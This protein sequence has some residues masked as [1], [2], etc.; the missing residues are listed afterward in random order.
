VDAREAE[1]A[2]LQAQQRRDAHLPP[3]VHRRVD[4]PAVAPVVVA[5][6]VVGQEL[7]RPA[8]ERHPQVQASKDVEVRP[9]VESASRLV[10]LQARASL[11]QELRLPQQERAAELVLALWARQ[12]LVLPLQAS[13]L[14]QLRE[15]VAREPRVP[16][17]EL[18]WPPP[19]SQQRVPAPRGLVSTAERPPKVR[20]SERRRGAS[21]PL[22][23]QHPSLPCPLWP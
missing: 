2:A 14:A 10:V 17:S 21:L 6:K 12:A 16:Q 3:G 1:P 8:A 4:S 20:L 22:S 19:A 11:P 15:R 7:V 23:L 18:A 13:P 5:E 9:V